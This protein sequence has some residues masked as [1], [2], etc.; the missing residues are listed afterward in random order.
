MRAVCSEEAGAGRGPQ[1]EALLAENAR[2]EAELDG[3]HRA[4]QSR[5]TIEQAKGVLVVFCQCAEAEAFDV[6]VGL[7]QRRNVRLRMLAEALLQ[8]AAAGFGAPEGGLHQWLR[9][10]LAHLGER[11]GRP[12]PR[13]RDGGRSPGRPRH[14]P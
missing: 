11:R 5:A 2:L 12:A 4:L 9:D 10:E 1:A 13:G 3:L 7:S 8:L 14:S 6:L